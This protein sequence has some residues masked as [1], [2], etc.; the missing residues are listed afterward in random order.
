LIYQLKWVG[1]NLLLEL[2]FFLF[3]LFYSL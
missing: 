3:F 1:M 2:H